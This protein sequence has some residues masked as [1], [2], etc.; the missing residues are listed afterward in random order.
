MENFQII[1]YGTRIVRFS[2]EQE[3]KLR[4]YLEKEINECGPKLMYK[5]NQTILYME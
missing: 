4:R 1:G 2:I 5:N 3:M